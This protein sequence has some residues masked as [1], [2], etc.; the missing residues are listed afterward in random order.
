VEQEVQYNTTP[1]FDFQIISLIIFNSAW[2]RTTLIIILRL[3]FSRPNNTTTNN[4]APA[5]GPPFS[6][7]LS[8]NRVVDCIIVAWT[9]LEDT[10]S[11]RP[12]LAGARTRSVPRGIRRRRHDRSR[13]VPPSH[14][15]AAGR[16]AVVDIDDE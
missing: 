11:S 15:T 13:Q 16:R 4:N 9:W 14:S 1:R 6:D 8:T 2:A 12:L 5:K 7:F 10:P 3:L